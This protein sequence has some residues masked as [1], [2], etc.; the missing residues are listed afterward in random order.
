MKKAKT[1]KAFAKIFLLALISILL[2]SCKD[3]EKKAPPPPD[4]KVVKVIHKETPIYREF[5]GQMYG[6]KD[7][8]IRARVSGFL[9][10]IFFDEGRNFEPRNIKPLM[11]IIGL[12]FIFN[13]EIV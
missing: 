6:L 5:V 1:S 4:I 13:N 12:Y 3:K 8:P 2:I 11:G 7:I 10:G 9:E